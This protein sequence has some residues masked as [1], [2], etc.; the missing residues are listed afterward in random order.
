M[1]WRWRTKGLLRT[2]WEGVRNQGKVRVCG[3]GIGRE[4]FRVMKNH[5][6]NDPSPTHTS[7]VNR[8]RNT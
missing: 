8:E 4:I 3:I 1:L 5:D 2:E 6:L 7:G